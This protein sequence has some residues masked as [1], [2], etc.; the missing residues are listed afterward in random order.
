[1]CASQMVLAADMLVSVLKAW[2][3]VNVSGVSTIAGG[4]SI[5]HPFRFSEIEDALQDISTFSGAKFA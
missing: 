4:L 3:P 2:I 5:G 1:M